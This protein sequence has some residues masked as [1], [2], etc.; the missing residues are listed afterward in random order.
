MLQQF[1]S[2]GGLR[3]A[4]LG[5]RLLVLFNTSRRIVIGPS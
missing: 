1:D 4:R 5:L 3:L 2:S